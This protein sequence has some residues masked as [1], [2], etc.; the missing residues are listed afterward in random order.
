MFFKKNYLVPRDGYWTAW[1]SAPSCPLDCTLDR[2]TY[3][4]MRACANP[5]PANGGAPCTG[6]DSE[7]ISR[8][9]E[10]CGISAPRDIQDKSLWV[11]TASS[12]S[13]ND[14]LP[15]KATDGIYEPSSPA[16]NFWT[17]VFHNNHYQTWLQVAFGERKGIYRTIL[18]G[19][20]VK[21]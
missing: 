14:T 16:L 5:A 21:Y 15:E 17:P 18:F 6:S 10:V 9:P 8:T 19:E 13:S 20:Y 1:S 12:S 7:T 11:A 2:E 4:A 3:V